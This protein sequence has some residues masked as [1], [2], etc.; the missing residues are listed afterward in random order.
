MADDRRLVE[1]DHRQALAVRKR[2]QATKVSG[3][4]THIGGPPMTLE[5]IEGPYGDNPPPPMIVKLQNSSSLPVFGVLAIVA[6]REGDGPKSG[7][8]AVKVGM[9]YEAVD[10]LPPGRHRLL[11]RAE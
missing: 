10:V 11:M 6:M 8:E 7:I 5:E 1:T 3:W 4:I 9:P 2:E